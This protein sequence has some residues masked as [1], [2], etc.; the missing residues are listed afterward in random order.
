[1]HEQHNHHNAPHSDHEHHQEEQHAHSHHD[2]H[3]H[4]IADFKK[5]FYISLVLAL[6][7]ILLSDMIQSFFNYSLTFAGDHW[8][9]LILASIIFFYGG[10]PF[11]TGAV[12]ELKQKSPGMMT[13][14]GFAITVAYVYSAATVLGLEGHDLFWELATLIAIMLLGHWVEMKSVSKAS[15]SM[16]SLV[17]LMPQEATK[18]DKTGNTEVIPVSDLKKGDHV[19]IKPGEKIPADGTIIDGKSSVDES[20][21]TGESV[22][23]EKQVKDEAIGGSINTS[24]S[25]TIEVS[26]TSEEGYLSQVVQLVKEAQESKS[27]TQKL[28][29]R[30]AKLLFYVAITAG[31]LTFVIWIS[32]GYGMEE[33]MTR[34][35]TV[36][37]ISCPHALG[38]AIPLVVARST[39]L[40]AQN[41]LFIRNRAGFEDARKI[42]TVVFDKTGTLT[43]GE[44]AVTDIISSSNITEKELLQKAASIEA[45]S[46]HPIAAG[47]VASAKKQ[48][49]SLTAP[50]T[51]DSITGAGV[52]AKL[53]GSW[54]LAVSPGYMDKNGI[55]YDKEAF[56]QLADAGKTVIF[57]LE[58]EQFIGMIALADQVKASSKE[59]VR[60]L[61][62]LGIEAQM[63]TGDN[64]TVAT[65]VAKEI[66]IDHVIAEVLPDQ[67]ADQIK[68]L[69]ANKKRTAMTGDGINDSPALA[70]ADLGVAVGA[71]TDVAM[72]TA[73]VVLVNSDPVDV[74]SIIE[75]SRLTY[76]KM[77]QNLW[78][79]AGYN[80]IA[81]PLAAGILAPWGIVLNPAVGAVLMSLSTII[82][83]FNA[84][85]L[86]NKHA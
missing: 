58:E 5:R 82:V 53:E 66:G 73:D 28:S 1:M 40:S 76:R 27:K 77:I 47:I 59:A 84:R 8:V 85:L 55:P 78:W 14:I 32:L 56:N 81:I 49:I 48:H 43:K 24:G 74:V 6:P 23:V 34:M 80:I 37:V 64:Q 9:E 52:K 62:E 60:R 57:V 35:V 54:L 65:G 31:I 16:E 33:A 44:F 18:I 42:D 21:L 10:W 7:I 39:Y 22:P 41:G 75:L 25:L 19:L 20:M 61:H 30:A 72:E 86:K 45:Q 3:E 68:Q 38:L 69:Q 51:F 70:T 46:E 4:M 63:L 50:E 12:D 79:A 36:L 71:G 17:E 29:D 15:D 2:H 13:L 11:L 26:K 67:K 83:A